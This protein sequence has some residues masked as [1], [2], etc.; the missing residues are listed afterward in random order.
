M[1]EVPRWLRAVEPEGLADY[2]P[3]GQAARLLPPELARLLP[4]PGRGAAAV[5]ARE[6]FEVFAARGIRYVLESTASQP[7]GQAIS[8]IDQV[9][10]QP[11][12]GTCLD[13]SLAY[14]SACL[15]AGLHPIVVVVDSRRGGPSHALVVVWLDGS[16]PRPV[17]EYPL[18]GVV[19]AAPPVLT[20]GDPLLSRVRRTVDG[21]GGF[22]AID[23]TSATWVRG[24]SGRRNTCPGRPA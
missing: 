13:V 10:G 1:N 2:V 15:D 7:G 3:Q 16:W 20:T 21:D 4:G 24:A 18:V 22:L 19:Y 12:M 23:V 11:R 6:I 9:L 17:E 5:K 8:T 14:A